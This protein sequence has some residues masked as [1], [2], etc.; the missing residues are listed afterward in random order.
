MSRE[1]RRD[2]PDPWGC[3]ESL[4]KKSSCAFFVPYSLCAMLA[5]NSQF[6]HLLLAP[7]DTCLDSPYSASLSV[8]TVLFI[9]YAPSHKFRMSF[10]QDNF[11]PIFGKG[12]EKKGFLPL[13]SE[14]DVGN[15]V[16]EGFGKDFYRK[17]NS[18]RRSGPFSEPPDF[19]D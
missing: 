13:F 18:V 16:N 15:S 6:T 9:V 7:F 12:S 2:V 8:H 4:C 11:E 1:N 19:E 10:R 17:G 14:K 3:S 5:S